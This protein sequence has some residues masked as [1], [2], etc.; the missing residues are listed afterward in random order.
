MGP[1]TDDIARLEV[2]EAKVA[3]LTKLVRALSLV[4][5][6]TLEQLPE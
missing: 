4:L 3:H 2:L 5:Q 6:E 1:T